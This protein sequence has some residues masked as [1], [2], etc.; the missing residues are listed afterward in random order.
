[1]TSISTEFQSSYAFAFGDSPELA[2]ELLNLVLAG[3][4]TA[5]CAALRDFGPQGE[6]MPQVG[7]RDVVLDGS[8]RAACAIETTAVTIRRFVEVDRDFAEA[9]GEGSFT[10]WQ[11]GHQAYFDRNGGFESDMQIVCERFQVIAVFDRCS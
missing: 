11:Q 4:K 10:D 6:P 7:R 1:M 9:E 2:D 5:T 8:G 3:R